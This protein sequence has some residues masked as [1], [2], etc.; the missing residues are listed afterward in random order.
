MDLHHPAGAF[1]MGFLVLEFK[2]FWQA[3]AGVLMGIKCVCL[4][5]AYFRR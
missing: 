5:T 4:E 3:S 2:R 1:N